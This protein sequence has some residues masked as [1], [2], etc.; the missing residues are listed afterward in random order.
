M[1]YKIK[2]NIAD[3]RISVRGQNLEQFFTDAFLGMMYIM[4]PAQ[5]FRPEKIEREISLDSIDTTALLT[6]FLNEVLSLA[7]TNKESYTH[8]IF[9]KIQPTGLR[10]K[11]FGVSVESFHRDMKEVTYH[12]AEV[13]KT[14]DGVWETTIVFN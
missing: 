10:A 13:K 2:E 3:T 9:Y 4:K 6:D 12:E 1:P 5:K 7:D 11:L 14:T 8:V